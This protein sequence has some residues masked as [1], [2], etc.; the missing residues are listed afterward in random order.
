MYIQL[1]LG[2]LRP[3][4]NAPG[5]NYFNILHSILG[6]GAFYFASI[7]SFICIHLSLQKISQEKIVQI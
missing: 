4:V 7:I 1:V 6:I 2:L 5:R 3:N